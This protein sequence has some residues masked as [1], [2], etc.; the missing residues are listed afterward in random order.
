MS[1]KQNLD[2]PDFNNAEGGMD[3]R[4]KK[5]QKQQADWRAAM[6]GQILAQSGA[7][8]GSTSNTWLNSLK[9][10]SRRFLEH[11]TGG[12]LEKIQ[13][14]QLIKEAVEVTVDRLFSCLQ[15]YAYEFN[16]VAFGTDLHVSGT[17]SGDVKEVLNYNKFREAEKTRTFFRARLSTHFYSLVIRGDKNLIDCFVMP[18]N[19]AMA[20][21]RLEGEYIPLATIE[22][23]VNEDGIV[24]RSAAEDSSFDSLEDL[25]AWL[26]KELI[27]QTRR[28]I[29]VRNRGGN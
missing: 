12:R 5:N 18:V 4:N 17:M 9:H 29:L 23:K 24:W 8:G 22:I 6:S 1:E 14:T 3:R 13:E 20:L 26:F 16:K 7:T 21:S 2:V 11:Y 25:C 19:H 15:G 27:E 28:A 10:D